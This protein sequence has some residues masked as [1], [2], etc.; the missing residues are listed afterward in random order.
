MTIGAALLLIAVGAVL[1][2]AVATT[3]VFGIDLPIIG[4]I[5][6]GVG[7]L[8][9]VLWL[10]VWLPRTRS[11]R[12]VYEP[13]PPPADYPRRDPYRGQRYPGDPYR[14]GSYPSDPYAGQRYSGDQYPTKPYP[15]EPY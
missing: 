10:V 12:P 5:L 15:G 11:R 2:F 1:R 14:A 4:D 9:L 7:A 6:M 13:P 3:T 8:G